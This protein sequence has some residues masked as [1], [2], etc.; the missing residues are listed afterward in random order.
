VH[1]YI[2]FIENLG[3]IIVVHTDLW[4]WIVHCYTR[5][6]LIIELCY[7]LKDKMYENIFLLLKS[8]A[9][10][11]MKNR[12]FAIIGPLMWKYFYTERTYRK[13]FATM[14]MHITLQWVL[15]FGMTA[16]THK[17]RNILDLQWVLMLYQ[18]KAL[19]LESLH[20]ELKVLLNAF[21]ASWTFIERLKHRI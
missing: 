3:C 19:V 21:G 13:S 6:T 17:S 7:K 18:G 2:R 5:H 10:C 9:R 4:G 14:K 15:Q 11:Y 20:N 1:C 16:W 12:S 8:Y